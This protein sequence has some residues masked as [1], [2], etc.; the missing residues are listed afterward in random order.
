[1]IS[2]C[3]AI[4]LFVICALISAITNFPAAV[5]SSSLN[6]AVHTLKRYIQESYASRGYEISKDTEL[7]IRAVIL[8]CWFAAQFIGGLTLFSLT[9]KYGRLG[10]FKFSVA[11]MGL[12]NLLQFIASFTGL[13]ELFFC[14]RFITGILS[15]LCD[16]CMVM[17]FQEC[18]PIHL[19]GTYSF[20]GAIG[21]GFCTALGMLF[22]NRVIFGHSI[23][24][25]T[26]IQLP[27]VILS[28]IFLYVF[29]PDT[30][31]FL[32]IVKRDQKEAMKSLVFFQGEQKENLVLLQQYA[33][34]EGM[35]QK[36]SQKSLFH[37]ITKAEQHE[38]P[39]TLMEIIKLPNMRTTVY[40]TMQIFV[41]V[42]PFSMVLQNSTFM[43]ESIG[44]E[45]RLAETSST[46]LFFVYTL[47][48]I[49]GML[50]V[51]HFTRRI[52]ILTSGTLSFV[53]LSL[54]VLFSTMVSYCQ[55]LK[56]LSVGSVFLYVIVFGMVLSPICWF[57]SSELCT[58]RY[59]AMIFI[60]CFG[61][62][63]VFIT[64]ANFICLVLFEKIGAMSFIP[65]F[66]LPFLFALVY[67]YRYLPET[68]NTEAYHVSEV[69]KLMSEHG[70]TSKKAEEMYA[71]MQSNEHNEKPV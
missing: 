12:G 8:N 23:V 27:V 47:S 6:T 21:F 4:Q 33:D 65:L 45:P 53:F 51:E 55:W 31:K 5:P 56:Y 34:T 57:I 42:L 37:I 15:P 28:L 44:V 14:G 71:R 54:F 29:L 11:G 35:G 66:L 1:M 32:M 18:T 59:R 24:L 41:M 36:V 48:C 20:L 67:L 17:Y 62:L 63:N 25:L 46:L 64:I 7:L 50:V 2:T 61:F 70:I 13:P 30:P 68:K 3:K 9:E 10:A 22:G 43:F 52:L 26:G 69:I 40:I 58:Q 38:K 19:R 49:V 60:V 39:A 16:T